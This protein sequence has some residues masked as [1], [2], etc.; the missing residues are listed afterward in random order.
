MRQQEEDVHLKEI[1]RVMLSSPWT[2]IRTYRR[3]GGSQ[4]KVDSNIAAPVAQFQANTVEL[5]AAG[6]L[7]VHVSMIHLMGPV[8]YDA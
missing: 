3:D 8:Y 5:G 1:M 7:G 2:Y 6:A 4:L